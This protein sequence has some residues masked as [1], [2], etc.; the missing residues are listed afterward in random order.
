MGVLFAVLTAAC[1]ALAIAVL[2][3]DTAAVYGLAILTCGWRSSATSAPDPSRSRSSLTTSATG[4]SL[5]GS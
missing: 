1:L 2:I 3:R 4:W 5:S